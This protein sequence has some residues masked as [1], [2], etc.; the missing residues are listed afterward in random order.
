MEITE[1][2]ALSRQDY[3][4]IALHFLADNFSHDTVYR[5]ATGKK[6]ITPTVEKAI[7][8]YREAKACPE[9]ISQLMETEAHKRLAEELVKAGEI[10]DL[11][12]KSA[13]L[14]FQLR[15]KVVRKTPLN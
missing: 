13:G 1:N 8:A 2:A 12:L 15:A 9:A 7:K 4:K 3:K 14:A 6:I 5:M 10:A 11:A